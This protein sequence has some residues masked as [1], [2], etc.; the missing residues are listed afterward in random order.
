MSL[1]DLSR[2]YAPAIQARLPVYSSLKG[3]PSQQGAKSVMIFDNVRSDD[4]S[5][6]FLVY[7]VTRM[8]V[9]HFR[10]LFVLVIAVFVI[11]FCVTSTTILGVSSE[12]SSDGGYNLSAGTEPWAICVATLIIALYILLL[13]AEPARV[14]QPFTSLFRRYLAFWIDFFIAMSAT[15]PIVGIL[16]AVIEWRRTGLF[17]W[18]FERTFPAPNDEFMSTA[19]LLLATGIV[20]LYYAAPLVR[21]KPSPG[22]CIL[23]YQLVPDPERTIT[24]GMA[25]LRTLLGFVAVCLAPFTARRHGKGKFW[26]DKLFGTRAVRLN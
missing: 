26:L 18:S 12:S 10:W 7:E 14:D 25:V 16:P 17:Q 20:V 6:A 24:I 4:G 11:A 1:G 2:V 3:R 5:T 23:G 8:T 19:T 21:R 13:Y 15:A 9:K 22:S